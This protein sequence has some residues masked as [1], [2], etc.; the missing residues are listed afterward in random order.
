[1]TAFRS[2]HSGGSNA[3][4][5]TELTVEGAMEQA[6]DT[7]TLSCR[8]LCSLPP[9]L[10][11]SA[12]LQ[13]TL[14]ALDVSRNT[15]DEL[16]PSGLGSF[17]ALGMLDVSRNRLRVLPVELPPNLTSLIALSNSFPPIC[18][19]CRSPHWPRCPS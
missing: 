14:T 6:T 13:N 11:S 18:A 4:Q 8:E 17:A 5:A 12:R 10:L 1:M 3:A 9:Q 7:L 2:Y 15:L 16:P 19:L